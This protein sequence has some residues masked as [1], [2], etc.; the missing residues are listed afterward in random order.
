MILSSK[1]IYFLFVCLYNTMKFYFKY[2]ELNHDE[3]LWM[4]AKQPGMFMFSI[5]RRLQQYMVARDCVYR[6]LQQYMVARDF[7]FFFE[8]LFFYSV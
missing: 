7:F 1:I 4:V 5:Y 8:G 2:S 6:R 3:M